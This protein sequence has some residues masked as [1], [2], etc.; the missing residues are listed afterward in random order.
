MPDFITKIV[1]FMLKNIFIIN[2]HSAT[3]KVLLA[4]L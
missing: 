1:F 3:Q 2:N 4:L